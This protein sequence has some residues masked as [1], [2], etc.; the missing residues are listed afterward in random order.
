MATF[1]ASTAAES[2]IPEVPVAFT[3]VEFNLNSAGDRKMTMDFR[4]ACANET[5]IQWSKDAESEAKL[6]GDVN[7][8][9][10]ATMIK[11]KQFCEYV[12]AEKGAKL[13]EVLGSPDAKP[14][15][16]PRLGW[17][18]E[19]DKQVP[20]T[21]ASKFGAAGDAFYGVE[22][23]KNPDGS[24]M[25]LFSD[26]RQVKSA[27]DL[28]ADT[29]RKNK[30]ERADNTISTTWGLKEDKTSIIELV[31]AAD[32]LKNKTLRLLCCQ[33]VAESLKGKVFTETMTL[34]KCTAEDF[35]AN[36]NNRFFTYKEMK[37]ELEEVKLKFALFPDKEAEGDSTR[38]AAPVAVAVGGGGGGV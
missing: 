25:E 14:T 37:K 2:V 31:E 18:K 6:F 12:Y 3:E 29:A 1:A 36:K 7:G 35:E 20:V 13:V 19:G 26:N 28:A 22:F 33:K 8:I 38:A 30:E 17:D 24:D 15:E 16:R 27:E 21:L 32:F 34:M 9:S 4:A 11:V 5:V 10:I 23:W